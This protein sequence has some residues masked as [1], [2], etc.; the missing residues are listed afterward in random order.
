MLRRFSLQRVILG[1]ILAGLA[2]RAAYGGMGTVELPRIDDQSPVTVFYR[3]ADPE[4]DFMPN[5]RLTVSVARGGVPLAGNGRLVVISHGSGAFPW[6]YA[7]LARALVEA[8]FVV[9][10]P[11]HR[12]DNNTD[13]GEPGPDSWTRRPG[14][15]SRAIDTIAADARFAPLLRLDRVGAYGMSAGGHTVLELAGASWSPA[16]FRDHCEA[17]IE[18]DFQACV[19]LTMQLTGGPLDG[20]KKWLARLVIASRF[21]DEALRQHRDQRVAVVV[22]AVPVAADFDPASLAGLK[23]PV[24]LVTA[25]KDLWLVP[26]FHSERVLQACKA[27]EHLADLP[28]AGHGAYLSPLP[29]GIGGLAGE[30]LNDPPG[31]DRR[32]VAAVEQRIVNYFKRHLLP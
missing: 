3:S 16:R 13:P 32:D 9:I 2:S 15:V 24:A 30:L 10:V 1:A 31:F 5:S 21:G 29:V 18:A 27:C 22:A 4:S 6:V 11:R 7:T 19:G 14:E 28:A 8:G 17:N 25:A 20:L 23:L 12:G 26:R